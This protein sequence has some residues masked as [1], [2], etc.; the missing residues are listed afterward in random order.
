M[1]QALNLANFANNLNTSGQTSN[2]GLQ[3]SSVTVS[4]G[5]G[6]SGGGAV[7]LG[8]TITLTNSAPDQTVSLTSGS[9][10]SVTGTYPNFTIA[11]S[12]GGGV[13]SLNGQTGAITNTGFNAIGSYT[14]AG[15][16]NGANTATNVGT[17]VAGSNLAQQSTSY[18]AVISAMGGFPT[19]SG[20]P[21]GNQGQSGTWRAMA[22]SRNGTTGKT[23]YVCASN[24]WVRVS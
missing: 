21:Y 6:M 3:N 5:T 9:G 16:L 12:G 20:Q 10:I 15:Y 1:T 19:A 18:G 11:T 2:G 4:A 23:G 13:T 8:G 17:T 14:V 24:I 7:S 22:G